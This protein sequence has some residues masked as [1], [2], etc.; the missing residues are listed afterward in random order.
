MSIEHDTCGHCDRPIT[1]R[2]NP[3]GIIDR[4]TV[5]HVGPDDMTTRGAH[6]AWSLRTIKL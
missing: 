1:Y 3:D 2:R 4:H 6:A 5:R